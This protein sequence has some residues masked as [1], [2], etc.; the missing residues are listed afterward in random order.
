MSGNLSI[1]YA[2]LVEADLC[3][4]GGEGISGY[5]WMCISQFLVLLCVCIQVA[6]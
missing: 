2:G 6:Q 3:F 5:A 4:T 1:A